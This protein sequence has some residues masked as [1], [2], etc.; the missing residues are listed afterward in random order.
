MKNMKKIEALALAGVTVGLIATTGC[1]TRYSQSRDLSL[2]PEP[3]A[4]APEPGGEVIYPK[5]VTTQ[6]PYWKT[7]PTTQ[8]QSANAVDATA[9]KT[10]YTT[11]TVKQGDVFSK[12]AAAH[13]IRTADLAAANP[14]ININKIKVGQ[15]ISIPTSGTKPLVKSTTPATQTSKGGTYVVKQGD[16]LGR[17]ANEH[18][19][20]L[21]DLKKANNLTGDKIIPGMRLT[22]PGASVASTDKHPPKTQQPKTD[23]KTTAADTKAVAPKLPPAEPPKDIA[24]VQPPAINPP[25]TPVVEPPVIVEPVA[26][27]TKVETVAGTPYVVAEG[28]DL[29]DIAVRWGVSSQLL[30]SVNNLPND[31]VVPGQTLIIPQ[32]ED[33]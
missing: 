20:K 8:V 19:V 5:P 2:R 13:G 28:E 29:L 25:E 14:G 18:G 22:I 32:R 33:R 11:Y 12:I 30:K 16:I 17:I 27:A 7:H 4:L 6:E 21:A 23:A 9:A 24:P 31:N 10:S 26:T 3:S 1:Q 15:K